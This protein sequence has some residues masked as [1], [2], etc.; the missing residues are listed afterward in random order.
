MTT[1]ATEAKAGPYDGNDSASVFAFDFPV[2]ADG[3]IRVI[4]TLISTEAETDLVLNG[5]N[6]YTVVRNVDQDNNPGGEITYKQAGI[7]TALP[8][9]KQLTIVPDFAFEQPTDIPNGGNFFASII[10]RALDRV[11][12]LVKQ[13]KVDVDRSV[14]VPVSSDTDPDDLIAELLQAEADAE[15]SAAAAAALL[16]DFDDRYLGAKAS[17]PTT[18][19]DGDPLIVGALYWNT[20]NNALRVYGGA[21]WQEIASSAFIPFEFP[22]DGVEDTFTLSVA[23]VSVNN[24]V[25]S[26]SGVDQRGAFTVVGSDII[27]DT[28]I[29]L[30]ETARGVVA[31]MLPVSSV[32]ASNVPY[33]ALGAGTVMR[34]VEE[35][36]Q[37][38]A[39]PLDFGAA[40]DGVTDDTAAFTALQVEHSGKDIDLLGLSYVVSAEPM[41]NR[42]FNGRF[43]V[44]TET[45]RRSMA[46]AP[47]LCWNGNFDIWQ[48]GTSFTSFAS[49][50]GV[51]D[52]WTFARSSFTAGST[53]SQQPG[54]RGANNCLRVQRDSGNTA[55]DPLTLVF[56]IGQADSRPAVN[57]RVTLSFRAR[58]GANFSSAS[59]A[60]TA[61]VK[62]TDA[63]SEQAITAANGT[64]S[65]G[66]ATEAG[67]VATLTT[68]WQTFSVSAGVASTKR[69]LA[70][71]LTFTPVGTAGAADYFEIEEVK[72]EVG[73][74]PTEFVPESVAF[75][76]MKAEEQYF[77][78]YNMD[79][80]P[81]TV[82]YVGALNVRARGTE[83]SAAITLPCPFKQRMRAIPTITIYSPQ[84]GAS[85]KM[86]NATV[87]INATSTH[88]GTGGTMIWNSAATVSTDIY[89]AH[90][91][92]E[93]KL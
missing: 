37:E 4:E 40:G 78:T 48:R 79:V 91:V 83:A 51:A 18:D 21:T 45:Y 27:F 74:A 29:P 72:L 61:Q 12:M 64:Y 56:N 84:T 54:S 16:D 35:K 30:G 23:P 34:N 46:P 44:A 2:Y 47:N 65:S 55:V 36:L 32:L 43:Q 68:D 38:G 69:Q 63:V 20:V 17:D 59:N 1:P 70:L 11:T 14:K 7:T 73:N 13:L 58:R 85:G 89:Y 92:A 15:A 81:G 93:A 71:R 90:V 28:P 6:G 62:S 39:T 3:D 87:D 67:V 31:Q 5:A 57:R 80:A 53:I 75:A 25:C 42:Y 19:N 22:G 41:G 33:L 24:V 9:A 86:T 66:D 49:R 50:N 77:K 52:G 26:I 10:E 88:T 60:L 76:T 82:S 8:S